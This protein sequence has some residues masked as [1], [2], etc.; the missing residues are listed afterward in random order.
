M[1]TW[2]LA[3]YMLLCSLFV[4]DLI[5]GMEELELHCR[6]RGRSNVRKIKIA[7][8]SVRMVLK[9]IMFPKVRSFRNARLF[10]ILFVRNFWRVCS[11][12]WLSVCNSV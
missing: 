8:I 4:A 9:A 1:Q 10:I 6:H 12:F 2:R 5:V 3:V 7:T 11:Q